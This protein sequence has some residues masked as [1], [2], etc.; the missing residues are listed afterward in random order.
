MPA[1]PMTARAAV[2][3]AGDELDAILHAIDHDR[4]ALR[5]CAE[6]GEP[7]PLVGWL[8]SPP[9]LPGPLRAHDG[10]AARVLFR[11]L[12]P[13]TAA[14]ES[15]CKRW[16]ASRVGAVIA[17]PIADL[18]PVAVAMRLLAPMPAPTAEALV[19]LVLAATSM[20]G[21][22]YA[23]SAEGAAGATAVAAGIRLLDAG[24]LDAV[25]VGGCEV[26]GPATL[27]LPGVDAPGEGAALALLE[28]HGDAFVE[29]AA[30]CEVA[31]GSALARLARE[32]AHATRSVGYVHAIEPVEADPARPGVPV[33]TTTRVTGHLRA[34]AGVTELVLAAG[35]LE[36]G[37]APIPGD[38]GD[39]DLDL[40]AAIVDVPVGKG[41]RVA[42]SL[43][44]RSS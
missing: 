12:A 23:C 38:R 17:A 40:D 14:I 15:A 16:G 31:S 13:S 44:A 37:R 39:P 24:A 34:A 11:A 19:E 9:P 20:R 7:P 27:R 5:P 2:N 6:L 41:G 18:D 21:P 26:L 4:S 30:V 1:Y 32:H 35:A 29:L 28:R 43:R 10:R 22:V 33:I 8:G 42:L 36:R 3:A 25:I